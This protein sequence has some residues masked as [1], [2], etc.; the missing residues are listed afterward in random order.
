[1]NVSSVAFREFNVAIINTIKSL[2]AII[3]IYFEFSSYMNQINFV[4]D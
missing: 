3:M 1:M 2:A 4:L